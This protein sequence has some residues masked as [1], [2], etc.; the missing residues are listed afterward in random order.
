MEVDKLR[1][2]RTRLHILMGEKK[3][4][5]INQLSKETGITRPTLTRIYN[6]TSNQLDFATLE[7]LCDFFECNLDELLYLDEEGD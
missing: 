4:R 6:E 5:S 3:I 1:K 2:V 7:K